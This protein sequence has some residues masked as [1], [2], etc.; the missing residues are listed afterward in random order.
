MSKVYVLYTGGTIGCEGAPLAPMPG[1]QFAQLILSMPGFADHHLNGFPSIDYVIDWYDAPLDSANITPAHWVR[2]AQSVLEVYDRYDGFVVLHG[3]DTLAWTASA[4]SFFLQGL[5]KPVLLTGSQLPLGV[6]RSDALRNLAS[7]VT[8]A[9]TQQINEVCVF[10][11]DVLLRGNRTMK[12]DAD[13]FAAFGSPNFSALA[14]LGADI[15]IDKSLLLPAPNP[16]TSLANP[17]VRT[18]AGMQLRK[19]L[20]GLSIRS[21]NMLFVFPGVSAGFL[22]AVLSQHG[23]KLAGL[24]LAAFG[25]GNAPNA[26]DFLTVLKNAHRNGIVLVDITQVHRGSVH[27]DAYQTGAS[28]RQAGAI[29]GY[30]LTPAAAFA[31]LVFLTALDL[32]L[33]E[34]E[35]LMQTSLAG[36]MTVH[37]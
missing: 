4:L 21:V 1:P 19:I 25:K 10:F 36:E 30:D 37:I 29:S 34:T 24:V 15:S 11:D 33:W 12:I 3:T 5:S 23:T 6:P 9:G 31:K 22:K 8:I 26:D 14:R 13:E 28:L 16:Q 35:T 18:E 20:A 32:P 7:A 17:L 27:L 2:I